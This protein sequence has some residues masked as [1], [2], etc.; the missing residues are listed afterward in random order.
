MTA[1]AYDLRLRILVPAILKAISEKVVDLIAMI[2]LGL[3]LLAIAIVWRTALLVA[4]NKS[5]ERIGN[6]RFV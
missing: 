5:N 1:F 6:S 2:L 4:P 3:I